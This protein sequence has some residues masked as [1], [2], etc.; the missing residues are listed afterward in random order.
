MRICLISREYPPE[1]GFGGIASYTFQHAHALHELGHDVEV[2]ALAAP[3]SKHNES[4][5]FNENGVIVHRVAYSHLDRLSMIRAAS[6]FTH[7]VLS[8]AYALAR[9]FSELHA[10]EPFDVAES[11]EHLAE[12]LCPALC[13]NVPL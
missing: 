11:P 1:T 12:G 8:A 10:A 7:Y 5:P 9:K 13:K 4:A 6:P 3:E 2:I